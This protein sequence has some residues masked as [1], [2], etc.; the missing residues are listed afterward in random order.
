M[1]TYLVLQNGL[2]PTFG[3]SASPIIHSRKKKEINGLERSIKKLFIVFT[4]HYKTQ[5]L[6]TKL[7]ILTLH[8]S[9]Q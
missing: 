2:S 4:I 6:V 9:T 1:K 8:G 5:G 7:M 3:H